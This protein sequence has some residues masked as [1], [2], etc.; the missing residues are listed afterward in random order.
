MGRTKKNTISNSEISNFIENTTSRFEGQ[1]NTLI[2]LKKL[3]NVD[4]T[5][6]I[7]NAAQKEVS[8]V[9]DRMTALSSMMIEQGPLSDDNIEYINSYIK[10][11]CDQVIEDITFPGFDNS[12]L[13]NQLMDGLNSFKKD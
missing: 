12:N 4:A 5:E 13:K 10:Q 6:V 11:L 8:F 9:I 3:G 1:R 2:F 7:S